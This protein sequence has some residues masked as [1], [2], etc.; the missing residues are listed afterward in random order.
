[1]NKIRSMPTW[2]V[3]GFAI[4]TGL[5][6]GSAFAYT[7]PD[8]TPPGITLVVVASGAG[9]AN[10][11]FLWRRL[12]DS[13][14]KPLYTHDADQAGRSTCYEQCDQEF[15]PFVADA[16]A[17]SAG[18]FSI[19]VRDDHVRQW[20]YQGQPLYRYSGKDP[21]GE[22]V[23]PDPGCNQPATTP[24]FFDPAN[25]HF[26]P[27]RGWRRA[28]YTPEKTLAMPADVQL[29]ALAIANGFGLVEAATHMTIYAAPLSHKL[30]SDWR[31][32]RASVLAQPIGAFSITDRKDY[33][34]RQW[35][36]KG[37]ALY[38]Y[39]GDYAPAEATGI[40]AGD[41]NIQ[42]ALVYRNFMPPAVQ[43]GFYLGRGPLMTTSRGMPLYY[44]AR[45]IG[46]HGGRD[47][48]YG[49]YGM[50]YNDAKSQ[51][52]QACQGDCTQSWKPLLAAA[53]AQA[54]GFW[55]LVIRPDGEK[56]W[57]FKGSPVYSFV[58]DTPG[59]IAGNN[60]SVIVYGGSQNE[61]AYSHAEAD[62]HY[63]APHVGKIDMTFAVGPRPEEIAPAPPAALKT[64]ATG[65]APGAAQLVKPKPDARAGAGFYWHTV[66]LFY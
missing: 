56:Q 1:M 10:P 40:F 42:A 11:T 17:K 48:R 23:D 5:V 51:G 7:A 14:G 47:T 22:P 9:T 66:G 31:P 37:E 63:P 38:T 43:I 34:T 64:P 57:A 65:A 32:V 49:G 30:S 16:R 50:T 24:E 58:G 44:V 52:A 36:Y 26:T 3:A 45:F 19:L 27:K 62:P 53:N 21:V 59:D 39:A 60:R 46:A 33:G 18:D 4:V 28:A 35:I 20:V 61:V 29:D 2:G 12:G 15:P 54:S 13:T 25:E 6:A 55:E 8:S 41:K